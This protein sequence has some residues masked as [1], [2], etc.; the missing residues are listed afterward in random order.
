[1]LVPTKETI[2]ALKKAGISGN[3]GFSEYEGDHIGLSGKFTIKPEGLVKLAEIAG[4]LYIT[5]E[6]SDGR[7]MIVL[8]K[9]A[10]E[11]IET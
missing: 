5:N 1:M 4:L 10:L 2:S 7:A 3:F 11:E 9:P 8:S 6:T